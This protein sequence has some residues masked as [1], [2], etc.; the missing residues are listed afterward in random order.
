MIKMIKGVYTHKVGDAYVD[1]TE[2]TPPFSE[3]EEKEKELVERGFAVYVETP[4][5]AESANAKTGKNKTKVAS[6][7]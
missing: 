1:E 3:T 6:G 7:L 2:K 4:G 5:K